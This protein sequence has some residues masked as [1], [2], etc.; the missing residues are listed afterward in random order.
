M[1]AYLEYSLFF[2]FF[3]FHSLEQRV[4]ENYIGDRAEG[5]ARAAVTGQRDQLPM[6]DQGAS[7]N[8]LSGKLSGKRTY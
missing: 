2:R 7:E 6:F 5:N 4:G 3:P 1:L 8:Q